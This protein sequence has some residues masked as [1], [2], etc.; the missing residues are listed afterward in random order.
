MGRAPGAGASAP[1]ETAMI[2]AGEIT[3]G[4]WWRPRRL[5]NVDS[6]FRLRNAMTSAKN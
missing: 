3:V 4:G 2:T 6:R 5:V 1:Y